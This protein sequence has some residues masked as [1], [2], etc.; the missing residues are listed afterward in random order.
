[1]SSGH[2]EIILPLSSAQ[3]E[4]WFAQQL[5]LDNPIYNVGG[6][7]E[8]LGPIDP[9]LF[10]AALRRT[11]AEAE[12]LRVRFVERDGVP[13]QIIGAAAPRWQLHRVD[14]S[15]TPDPRAAA[16]EWMRKDLA[17]PF[18]LTSAPLFTQAL[19]TAGPDRFLWYQGAHHLVLDA[20]SVSLVIRRVAEVYTALES[21][22]PVPP[23]RF[24]S[25]ASVLDD[26]SAFRESRQFARSRAYWR[27]R[28]AEAPD[29]ARLS[30]PPATM[31]SAFLRRTAYL[32]PELSQRV[33]QV[34]GSLGSTLSGVMT[35]AAA[36]YLHRMTGAQ[37]IVLG[38]AV[39]G[40]DS[41]R[42]RR[43]PGMLAHAVPLR[44]RV[45][46]GTTMTE[47]VRQTGQETFQAL[48]HQ[49]YGSEEIRRDLPVAHGRQGLFGMLLNHMSFD[50]DLRMGSH[51][52]LFHN[53]SNGPVEDLAMA[54]YDTK[55]GQGIR[56]DFDAN[57]EL[58]DEAGNAAHQQRFVRL[59]GA[60]VADPGVRVGG[61]ELLSV[62]ERARV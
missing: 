35:A 25:L 55:D 49:R 44:L 1:M 15:G 4:V 17:R 18:D 38:L 23:G 19:F 42:L 34:A 32:P 37:D 16:E 39:T 54:V 11:V 12:T 53:I 58:Y 45:G 22:L 21:G 26:E 20:L 14:V 29:P 28:L 13:G 3:Q 48:R 33:R 6:C 59:L 56:L 27:E 51:R 57:P 8:I 31:P 2:R 30:A 61:V 52:T 5:D 46:A 41:S 10:E 62:G 7:L 43:S 40:R 50:Y 60:V 36:G 47:L 9:A 24:G